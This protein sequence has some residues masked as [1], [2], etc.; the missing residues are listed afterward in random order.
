MKIMSSKLDFTFLHQNFNFDIK[1]FI[2]ESS[3]ATNTLFSGR[4]EPIIRSVHTVLIFYVVESELPH[5][6]SH[7]TSL[8]EFAVGC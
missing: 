6:W 5:A 8:P 7:V 2:V 1:I 3:T 4:F